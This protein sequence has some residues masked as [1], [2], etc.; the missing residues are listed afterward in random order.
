[1]DKLLSQLTQKYELS[2][3]DLLVIYDTTNTDTKKVN[4]EKILIPQY[5]PYSGY[6]GINILAIQLIYTNIVDSGLDGI[7]ARITF[8]DASRCIKG[9]DGSQIT[10]GISK[11]ADVW[12]ENVN[13]ML[14]YVD[15][16]CADGL[17]GGFPIFLRVNDSTYTSDILVSYALIYDPNFYCGAP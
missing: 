14:A 3:D 16:T 15:Y 4:V 5:D 2:S 11:D 9:G 12:S 8:F 7:I 17:P 13:P 6:E 10:Y 1:M